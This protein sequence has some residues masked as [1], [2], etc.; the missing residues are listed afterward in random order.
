VET[1]LNESQESILGKLALG[2][3]FALEE[4]QRN[5]WLE[6]IRIL[7]ES[8]VETRG[9]YLLLEYAIPRVGKRVDAVLLSKGMVFAIEFKVGGSKYYLADFDQ[10]HDYALDL[11]NFHELS[12]DLPI[13]PVLVATE[14]PHSQLPLIPA[15]D[16]VFAPVAANKDNLRGLVEETANAFDYPNFDPEAWRDSR[17]KPTP[18]I[19]QAAQA[20]Y[21]GHSVREISRS[22]AGATNLTETSDAIGR[23]I[24]DA[25]R[26]PRKAICFVTGVPGAGKTLA[27][28]NIANLRL[29]TDED[30]HAVFLSGNGP[31]VKLLREALA[32]NVPEHEGTRRKRSLGEARS[33]TSAFIQ[34]VH[35]FRDA[36]VSDARP[37]L[38][39]V[40]IF[41]EAQRAWTLAQTESFMKR[42]KGLLNF[43]MSEP[44]FLISVMDRHSDW[45][46]I[47]CLVGG[48]QEIN[49]G[50]AGL[51]AWFEALRERFPTWDVYVS[52]QLQGFEYL[53][54]RALSDLIDSN[55]IVHEPALHLAV[56]IRSFRSERVAD[57]VRLLLE[58]D[59]A[60]C[61][62]LYDEISPLYPIVLTRNLETARE[63]LRGQGRGTERYGLL[64][65][66]GA[67]RLRAIG[68]DVKSP[69]E[70]IP[71]FLNG[72]DDVRSS[73]YLEA[74][75]TEFD[76]Q[77][78]EL[79]WTGVVWDADLRSVPSGWQYTS[80]RGS[81][82]ESVKDLTRQQ[83]LK[84]TYRVLL[85]RARQGM[86]IVVPEGNQRDETRSPEFYD[87]TFEYLTELGIR[88]LD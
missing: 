58:R 35:H 75:A 69:C 21:L 41:D 47:V 18:T 57:F 25:K 26:K 20:L 48:G 64:T 59:A 8:L 9:G 61:K 10:V 7:R 87:R 60:S 79:D 70:V 6:E 36:A 78:L 74:V 38:E 82:W 22:D 13:L 34:N 63:W 67:L 56:S 37:P 32:R 84:N 52:N 66:S 50:E 39:R 23:I 19:V 76:V 81:K 14:A 65:S 73:Y 49:T 3:E 72:K 5:A 15:A 54:D 83:Y 40:V 68:I 77:G 28:L 80:F 24:E 4:L 33:K 17:Y 2:H 1:F 16:N 45:A 11:K 30:E 31:L 43:G 62:L 27:G 42:K 71:W 86:V 12:H 53:G 55:R 46:V 44:E 85:T 29:Q 88:Q 51:P